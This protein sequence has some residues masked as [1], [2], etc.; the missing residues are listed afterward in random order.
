MIK[1]G[2]EFLVITLM[3]NYGNKAF[4]SNGNIR[5][6]GQFSYYVGTVVKKSIQGYSA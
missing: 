1:F 6:E 5:L 3:D 4:I 2:S